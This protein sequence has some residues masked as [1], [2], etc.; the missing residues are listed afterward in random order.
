MS[1]KNL[2]YHISSITF[3]LTDCPSHRSFIPIQYSKNQN[4]KT[5]I[6]RTTNPFSSVFIYKKRDERE[7]KKKK[8]IINKEER[9]K[10]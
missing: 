2:I 1:K 6:T 4:S 9:P 3:A 8:E 10:K 7:K 5:E